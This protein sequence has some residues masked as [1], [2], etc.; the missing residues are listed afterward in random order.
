MT[1]AGAN[2]TVTARPITITAD[3]QTRLYG[4]ANPALTYTVGGRGLANGDRLDGVLAT[5]TS[6]TS[7]VGT[8]AIVQGTLAASSNYALT[9]RGADLTVTARPIT[10][11]AE[12]QARL[13]GTAN[14][15]LTYTVGGRGLVAGDPLTGALATT[16]EADSEPGV[17]AITQGSLT[18]SANYRLGFVGAN[19]TVLPEPTQPLP[20]L[21]DARG[22]ASTAERAARLDGRPPSPEPPLLF[23]AGPDG[24]LNV[25]DPRF[26][27]PLV[28]TGQ[29]GGCFLG[30]SVILAAPK[31]Q[32][33]LS[34]TVR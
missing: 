9:Y 14:P 18:A 11:I 23:L 8:Y 16:A 6:T 24:R 3:A 19:L 33:G 12:P 31:P 4:D 28:C 5:P 7:G 25:A 29:Q 1:Y 34:A 20:V 17:Y 30:P 2:L 27:A 13:A 32:A 22:L 26:E 15:P 10:V 21:L